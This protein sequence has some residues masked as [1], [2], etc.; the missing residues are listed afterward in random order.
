[1]LQKINFMIIFLEECNMDSIEVIKV[2]AYIGKKITNKVRIIVSKYSSNMLPEEDLKQE[3]WIIYNKCKENYDGVRD[4]V[5]FFGTCFENHCI[6]MFRKEK[7]RFRQLATEI[8]DG[9]NKKISIIDLIPS[10][11]NIEEFVE[12]KQLVSRIKKLL[13][14]KYSERLLEVY[15]TFIT[16]VVLSREIGVSKEVAMELSLLMKK[17]VLIVLGYDKKY[18]EKKLKQYA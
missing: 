7:I 9:D 1:M 5:S 3:S 2:P 11:I 4:F 15:N 8:E 17:V 13:P 12:Y 14:P 16:P 18:I 6:D 10:D